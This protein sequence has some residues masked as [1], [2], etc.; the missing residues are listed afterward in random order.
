M[1]K[2]SPLQTDRLR[3]VPFTER[4]LTDRYVG[5][6]NDPEVV[7]YS[8]QRFTEHTLESCHEYWRSFED[9]PNHFWAVEAPD[10]DQP[11]IGTMTAYVDIH[12]RVADVGILIGDRDVWGKGY[13]SEAFGTVARH[14][15]LET[16][17]RKV[18]AGTV[19]VNEGMLGIMEKVGMEEDGRRRRQ[20]V[21]DG[22]EVDVVHGALFREDV[23]G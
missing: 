21:V 4:H 23:E 10:E 3:I 1:A 2:S 6:L 17:V 5:W 12:H 16:D 19:E 20:A 11:Y 14:L 7:R 22:T 15:L 13:G 8:D 9:T 18:T